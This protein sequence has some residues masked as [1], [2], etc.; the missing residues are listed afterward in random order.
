MTL[1]ANFSVVNPATSFLADKALVVANYSNSENPAVNNVT[2]SNG[3]LVSLTT[4]QTASRMDA[5][6]S[7][8]QVNNFVVNNTGTV[9]VTQT[10]FG[11]TFDAS[12]LSLRASGN[13]TT[14]AATYNGATLNDM[15]ALYSDDNTNEFVINN[16]AGANVLSIGNYATSYYGRADTTVT[17]SGV[18]SNTTWSQ[19]DSISAGH[20]SIATW[21]GADFEALPNTNPDSPANVVSNIAM[22]SQGD[23]QGTISVAD[24]SALTVTNNASGAITGD[25][26][27]IDITPLVYAAALA[28]GQ[29]LPVA[30]SGTNAGPR[31]SNIENYGLINGNFYLG[32]GTHVFDNASSGIINGNVNVD[33]SSSVATF[34]VADIY[35][36]NSSLNGTPLNGEP[37]SG[38]LY[39][40]SGGTDFAGNACPASG[41]STA[42]AGCAK[43]TLVLASYAGGQSLTLT[44]EGTLNGD[45]VINDQ[46][47]SVN[48][49]TLTGS[50]FSG[51]VIAINGTGSNTLIL[52]GVTRLASIQ[53]FSALNLQSSNVVVANGVSMV[54][55][56]A[57]TTTIY[58]PGGTSTTPSANIGSISG[59][60]TLGGPT[61]IVPVLAAP[62]ANGAIYQIASNVVGASNATVSFNSALV[63]FNASQA[64]SGA[65]LLKATVQSPASLPGVS[66]AGAEALS[67]IIGYT[68]ANSN[69]Q[70]LGADIESIPA[71]GDTRALAEQLRPDVSGA[72]DHV[73]IDIASLMQAQIDQRITLIHGYHNSD[74]SDF[75]D[76]AIWV[77]GFGYRAAGS[78]NSGIDPY[79]ADSAGAIAGTD[80][81][82]SDEVLLGGAFGYATSTIQDNGITLGDHTDVD[83]YRGT[84][85]AAVQGSPWRIDGSFSVASNQYTTQRIANFSTVGGG[86]DTNAGQFFGMQYTASLVGSYPF[87]MR[88]GSVS[89]VLSLTYNDINQPT[90][91]ETSTGMSGLSYAPSQFD[92]FRSSLGPRFDI[93]FALG[94]AVALAFDASALWTHEFADAVPLINTSFGSGNPVFAT[95][96][97]P[98]DRD[99]LDLDVELALVSP[100]DGESLSLGYR[101]EFANDYSSQA[102]VLR[103][104]IMF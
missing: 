90:Y 83:T 43:I 63:G 74:P 34:S 31:D 76:S 41:S 101:A 97:A 94:N 1:T 19:A 10:F 3:G 7:D 80:Y 84:I 23:L 24:T 72:S 61:T 91:S 2:L 14:Y 20:W 100:D 62:I 67:A 32:S 99:M 11:G 102:G 26:L 27:A 48:S 52:D 6:V 36:T 37:A 81:S 54:P 29:P 85:Y 79:S 8:S 21:A 57:L 38:Q 59:T 35:S 86:T 75:A 77:T 93:P 64:P 17:N 50:G 87:W 69:I 46:S 18:I 40:S 5:I 22:N 16:A 70:T 92:S 73:L 25:V 60:L 15:A 55:G 103:A 28:S 65:L 33:Q 95:H 44:N 78:A 49:I 47:T 98:L 39:L 66:R 53:N 4:N 82:L 30:I 13:P 88:F 56:S 12:N 42:D 104:R 51:N 71:A 9:S 89:P 45:I 68:G 58:G 96:G